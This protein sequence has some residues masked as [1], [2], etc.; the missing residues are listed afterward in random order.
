MPQTIRTHSFI[1]VQTCGSTGVSAVVPTNRR[2]FVKA[3]W[4]HNA[5][6]ASRVVFAE[7]QPAGLSLLQVF[8]STV[9]HNS[10]TS[11]TDIFVLEEG[12]A[13]K[14]SAVNPGVVVHAGGVEFVVE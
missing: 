8:V 11:I 6:G 10:Q 9:A 4:W 12:D 3:M 2:W 5:T 7:I 13:L 14:M 1:P